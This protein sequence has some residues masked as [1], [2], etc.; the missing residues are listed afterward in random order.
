MECIQCKKEFEGRLDA[1]FCSG[2]C[3]AKYNR[4]DNKRTD[5]VTDKKSLF[6][7]D[8]DSDSQY[9]R[10][11]GNYCPSEMLIDGKMTILFI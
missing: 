5:N 10:T 2:S 3:R 11:Y 7:G 6:V 1:R 8:T 4:T 9:E